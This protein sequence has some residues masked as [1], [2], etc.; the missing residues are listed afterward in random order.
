MTHA[1]VRSSSR[2]FASAHDGST[3]WGHQ[4]DTEPRPGIQ[5]QKTAAV[6]VRRDVSDSSKGRR[7]RIHPVPFRGISCSAS[8][9]G[10]PFPC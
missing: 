5:R 10:R 4:T 9:G 2:R 6:S 7:D 8:V 3:V 1:P